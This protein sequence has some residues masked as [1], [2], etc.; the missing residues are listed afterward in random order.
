V[1]KSRPFR[2]AEYGSVL[3]G[4]RQRCR[5]VTN[6]G[7]G[8]HSPPISVEAPLEFLHLSL[9]LE[10]K[11][12]H[13]FMEIGLAE[14]HALLADFGVDEPDRGIGATQ[15]ENR[16]WRLELCGLHSEG[17][18][19]RRRD[20]DHLRGRLGIFCLEKLT[21]QVHSD[22]CLAELGGKGGRDSDLFVVTLAFPSPFLRQGRG[23]IGSA[24]FRR[25]RRS[26]Q[27]TRRRPTLPAGSQQWSA[28]HPTR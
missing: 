15:L 4:C 25:L 14:T 13:R 28:L 6:R 21:V 1:A 17:L 26:H 5:H 27:R 16:L 20:L 19:H 9:H 24:G 23:G 22:G 2:T 7:T 8:T 3:F 11:L 10:D 12:P 18:P